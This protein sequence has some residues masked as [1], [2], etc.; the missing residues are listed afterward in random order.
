MAEEI[1]TE[2]RAQCFNLLDIYARTKHSCF[3]T[4]FFLSNDVYFVCFRPV[5]VGKDDAI[6]YVCKYLQF[7]VED[8]RTTASAQSLPFSI[9]TKLDVALSIL[10]QQLTNE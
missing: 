6:R 1:T 3:V 2:E 8:M 4:E 10:H 9:A 7:D 5:E